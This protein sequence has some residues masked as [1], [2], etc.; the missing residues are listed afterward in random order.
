MSP[1]CRGMPRSEAELLPLECERCTHVSA[2][3]VLDGDT[4][5]SPHLLRAV[6]GILSVSGYE[7]LQTF[8][9]FKPRGIDGSTLH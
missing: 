3:I 2:N 7:H 1:H 5:H 8:K 9:T 6:V 4:K